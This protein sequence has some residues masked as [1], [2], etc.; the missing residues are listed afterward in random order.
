MLSLSIK[1][2]IIVTVSNSL[3]TKANK[4]ASIHDKRIEPLLKKLEEQ[5]WRIKPMKKG[6]MCYPPD[7]SKQAVPIHK[8]PSDVR[9]LDNCMKYLRR[10]GFHE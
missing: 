9:W 4:E 7:K 2:G 3:P 5:G 6:W 10:G 8:T 1:H